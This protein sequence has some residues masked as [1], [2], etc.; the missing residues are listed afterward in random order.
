MY[1]HMYL[2]MCAA[3]CNCVA[4]KNAQ[5]GKPH[6]QQRSTYVFAWVCVCAFMCT[7]VSVYINENWKIKQAQQT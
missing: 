2:C 6:H 3:L 1:I 4:A 7:I 5:E